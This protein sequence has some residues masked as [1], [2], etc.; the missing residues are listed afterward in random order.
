MEANCG[1]SSALQNLSKHTQRDNSLQRQHHQPQPQQQNSIQNFR[2]TN[3]DSRLNNDFQRFN[4]G[5]EF[6]NA[7]MNQMNTKPGFP[8]QQQ[9]PSSIPQQ[10]QQT[11]WV[12]DFSNLSINKPTPQ[13]MAQNIPAQQN[14]DW[15]QQFIQNQQTSMVSQQQQQE[16]MQYQM[17][18]NYALGQG[19]RMNM[20]TDLSTP[21]YAQQSEHQE[22]HKIEQQQ[23]QFENEFDAIEKELQNQHQQQEHTIQIDDPDKEKFA[24]TARQVEQSMNNI[25]SQNM[26]M[27]DKF[28]NSD[29]LKLMK[30]IG[31]R[32]VE[33]EGDKL[34]DV[35]SGDDIRTT[36]LGSANQSAQVSGTTTLL[37]NH[38]IVHNPMFDDDGM[39]IQPVPILA[40]QAVDPELAHEQKQDLSQE[41]RLPDPLAHIQDGQLGGDILD[42][43]SAARI[44]SGGQVNMQDWLDDSDDDEYMYK[45]PSRGR[46][47]DKAWQEVFDDYRHDD[48]FH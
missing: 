23:K 16:N 1:P 26:E 3:G 11:G 7:F 10:I 41:N 24:E 13:I 46:I 12:N 21:V 45:V 25:N 37:D 36:G 15:H 8:Q 35:M 34:V 42:P 38:G 39:T 6:A 32:Q 27:K 19:F 33:L 28:Q 31:N 43:F 44:V 29:F 48:D 22:I 17:T 47:V 5:N 20:R 40:P 30:S 18:P 4:N 14:S 9:Q 2:S